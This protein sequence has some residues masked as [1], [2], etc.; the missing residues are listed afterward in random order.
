M[1]FL[2]TI[3]LKE[4]HLGVMEFAFL[5]LGIKSNLFELV[6]N[7]S[8]MS[9]MFFHVLE[10]NKDVINVTN[11]EIIQVFL[12]NIVHQMLKVDN[13]SGQKAS[14]HISNGHN[15]FKKQSSIHHLFKY[16]SSYM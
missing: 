8:N 2:K 5:Q 1:P 16:T 15:K 11:H 10:K 6:Q 7:K 12:R 4:F 3:Y 14:P 9:F 13:W